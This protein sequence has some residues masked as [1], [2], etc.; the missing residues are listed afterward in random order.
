MTKEDAVIGT[1]QVPNNR[2]TT[3]GSNFGGGGRRFMRLPFLSSLF[4]GQ[5]II[6]IRD[7]SQTRSLSIDTNFLLF[8]VPPQKPTVHD[9]KGR[10]LLS[11][12]G[13]YKV[14]DEAVVTCKTTGGESDQK[15]GLHRFM[16]AIRRGLRKTL[17]RSLFLLFLLCSE[18]P[19]L[20]IF[21]KQFSQL[22]TPRH[23]V[24]CGHQR[25]V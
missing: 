4:G 10:R 17:A 19:C 25:K 1:S 12:L 9:E 8:A 11:K 13:P 22:C 5:P 16:R 7:S 24:L 2:A 6:S 18:G 15:E 3:F 20:I 14:G 21:C 23:N